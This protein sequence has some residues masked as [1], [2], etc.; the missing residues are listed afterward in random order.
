MYL[1]FPRRLI[2]LSYV[3][4]TT[5]H[6]LIIKIFQLDIILFLTLIEPSSGLRA[7]CPPII[8]M[9]TM[10]LRRNCFSRARYALHGWSA[11]SS[12]RL[13]LPLPPLLTSGWPSCSICPYK[14]SQLTFQHALSRWSTKL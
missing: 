11:Y 1:V 7:S 5:T 2:L 6:P 14:N 3:V 9:A 8:Y 4:T 12:C 13:L 10:S